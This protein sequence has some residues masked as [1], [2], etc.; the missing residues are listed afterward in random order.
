M[1]DKEHGE[2]MKEKVPVKEF[3]SRHVPDQLTNAKKLCYRHRPD[4]IK[5]RQPD[6]IDFQQTQRQLDVLPTEDKAAVTHIWSIFSAAPPDQRLLILRGL[7]STCCMPQLSFLYNAI[8]P[9]VRIDFMAI[10]PHEI[11]LKIFSYLDA[12]SLCTA[13]QV[14]H[15]W[16]EVADDE[17]VWH[18]MCEQHIDKKCTKCGWGLPLLNVKKKVPMKRTIEPSDEP[19]RIACGSS[20]NHGNSSSISESSVRLESGKK[21]KVLDEERD[22]SRKQVDCVQEKVMMTAAEPIIRRRPWKEVYS[23][24]LRVER[25]WRNNRYQSR[26]LNGHTDGVMCVQFCD[27]S[28]IVMTGSY[29]KTV[30]IWNLETCELIRTLTGHTRCVRALQF[31]EAKLVTGSMDHTLKIWNWQSG[32]CIRTLE[33]HTGGILSLQFNSRLLAS[34]STDHSVRIWNFSAGE[35]YS[36]TGHTEWVNSVRFCQDDTMLISASDDSTIRLW[37]LKNKSCLCV[38]NGHVGQVQIALPSPKGFSHTLTEQEAPLDLSSSR[39]DDGQPGCA[40]NKEKRKRTTIEQKSSNTV[41]DNPI[42]ISG[43]LDNTVKVWDMTTGNCIRTLFGHVEGVWSLAYDTLRIVSGS[44]DSTVRVWDLANGRCMH[45]LEGHSGPVTAVA[46][47][48]TKII[49]ASDDGDVKI[50]DYGV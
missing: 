35:C 9:L 45:A 2:D 44:H 12:K 28:N 20:M 14:S 11:T 38:Y 17:A 18:R 30:R 47:S 25:N 37:D 33:G 10:L 46:L 49:S 27:G 31:D 7:L 39:N 42:I 50:W 3:L 41:T 43:S 48:D 22:R 23:E 4:L 1:M 26:V 19:L 24:R 32:K 21:I 16:K 34:G 13:A 6:S 8:K 40:I 15:T 29:D 36:L 5:R